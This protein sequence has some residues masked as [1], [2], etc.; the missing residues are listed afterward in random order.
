[1]TAKSLGTW[2]AV[3]A[4]AAWL[5]G[6]PVAAQ[7]ASQSLGSVRL[8]QAVTANGQSLPA[9]TYTLRLSADPVTPVVGQAPES[10]RWVEFVQGGQVRGKELAT[11]VPSAEVKQI[12][13]M[14]PPAAGTSKVQVL[15]GADYLRVWIN[16]AGTHYLLHLANEATAKK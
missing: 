16:R 5:A 11:V 2:A 12:A 1:M 13:K 15:K 9:G 3:C 14:A 10:S 7:T 6:S 8:S 4:G